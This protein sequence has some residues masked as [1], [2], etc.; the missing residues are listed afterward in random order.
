MLLLVM[1]VFSFFVS[2]YEVALFSLNKTDLDWMKTKSSPAAK[3]VLRLLAEPKPVYVSLLTAGTFLNIC[4]ILLANFLLS[5]Q[6]QRLIPQSGLLWFVK[7]VLLSAGLIFLVRILPKV[8][9]TQNNLRFALEAAWL[10]E[11][12]HLFLRQPSVHLVALADRIGR[13]AQT[14]KNE[15]QKLDEALDEDIPSTTTSDER[16]IL[17]GVIRFGDISVRQIMKARLD[18]SGIDIDTPFDQLIQQIESLHYSRLP[19]YRGSLDEVVG[20]LHTKELLPYL[21][22]GKSDWITLL[23]SPFFVPEH[24]PIEDLFQEFQQRRVH[25]AVVVDEFGGTSGIVTLEDVLEEVIGEIQDEFDEENTGLQRIDEVT[26]LIDG[27]T[28]LTEACRFM[29]QPIDTF[30][31]IKGDSDTVAGLVLELAGGFPQP[32]DSFVAGDFRFTV[33]QIDQNRIHQV[34]IQ[35][36]VSPYE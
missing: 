27:R 21:R 20:I 1:L 35:I 5:D 16:N 36:L 26:F 18:V 23:R 12:L 34:R 22:S 7:V 19:V 11:G 4:L 31:S 10:I 30:D 6:L 2:G 8:W 33:L 14:D 28:A 32:E 25:F 13:L 29:Q 15:K 17:R 9:A 24:K 3:R